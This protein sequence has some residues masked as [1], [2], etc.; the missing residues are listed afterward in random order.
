VMPCF[1]RRACSGADSCATVNL[2]SSAADTVPLLPLLPLLLL[3]KLLLRATVV[4]RLR[5]RRRGAELN[6]RSTAIQHAVRMTHQPV[7]RH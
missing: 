6:T 5:R 4:E 3:L 2:P 7:A 1:A